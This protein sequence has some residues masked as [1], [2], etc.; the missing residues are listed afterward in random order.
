MSKKDRFPKG[1]I[2]DFLQSFVHKASH[3]YLEQLAVNNGNEQNFQFK[4]E[5]MNNGLP[6]P[7]TT[8]TI[9]G[10]KTL[11]LSEYDKVRKSHK[12]ITDGTEIKINARS[13]SSELCCPICL[14]LLKN[15]MT[16]KVG[17]LSIIILKMKNCAFK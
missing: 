1:A 16:T 10:G 5:T 13:L 7:S 6:G 12:A 3:M 2:K 17:R 4:S 9:T 11:E 15:T 14:D 8:D